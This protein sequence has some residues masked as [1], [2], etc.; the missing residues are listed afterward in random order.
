MDLNN[1]VQ[2]D[3]MVAEMVYSLVRIMEIRDASL[4]VHG[5]GTAEISLQFG[6]YLQLSERELTILRWGTLLHDIGMLAM[7]DFISFKPGTLSPDEWIVIRKHPEYGVA[8][9]AELSFLADALPIIESH[10]ECWDGSGYPAGKQGEEISFLARICAITNTFDAMTNEKIY[11]PSFTK[12]EALEKM[13]EDSGKVF[14]PGLFEKFQTMM[15]ENTNPAW[16]IDDLFG[17]T[18]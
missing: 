7:P 4:F 1:T 15:T 13:G 2:G 8:M 9:L 5:V 3:R 16:Q 11:R 17:L 14:D 10:H 6:K 18:H 12:T